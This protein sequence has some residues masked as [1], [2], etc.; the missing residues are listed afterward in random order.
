MNLISKH[1]VSIFIP[2]SNKWLRHAI[3]PVSYETDKPEKIE[4]FF[5]SG[6]FLY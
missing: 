1:A 4:K 6:L 5:L 3:T 2:I